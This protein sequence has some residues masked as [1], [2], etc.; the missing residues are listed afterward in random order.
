MPA[1][2]IPVADRTE[3]RRAAVLILRRHRSMA[4]ASLSAY[5]ASVA[6]GL[7]S[8]YLLGLVVDQVRNGTDR[9]WAIAGWMLA[10]LAIEAVT[11]W[12]ATYLSGVLAETI[13]AELREDAIRSVLAAPLATVEAIPVGELLSRVT[14]DIDALVRGTRN[15]LPAV[16]VTS[17]MM[18]MTLG[19]MV[20]LGWE[21]LVAFLL[22]LPILIPVTR[23]FLRRSRP[24]FL[25]NQAAKAVAT[26]VLA[27]SGA[28]AST[29]A[30][31]GWGSWWDRRI[32]NACNDVRDAERGVLRLQS[33]F[34]VIADFGRNIPIAM[35]LLLG[36]IA[37]L[38]DATPLAVVTAGALYAQNLAV[39]I[40]TVLAHQ[41]QLQVGGA[42]FARIL[43]LQGFVHSSASEKVLE[44][45]NS[46]GRTSVDTTADLIVSEVF[47]SYPCDP[48][49][50]SVRDVLEGITLTVPAG[51]RVAIVGPSGAGKTTLGRVISG[52]D[53]PRSGGIRYGDVPLA[54]L[55]SEV[56]RRT[57]GMLS[58][59]SFVFSGSVADN[60]RIAA[61]TANDENLAEVLAAV[62]AASLL[63]TFMLDRPIAEG[64]RPLTPVEEQQLS[65]ARMVLAKPQ[66][67]V[68]DEA[69]AQFDPLT[70]RHLETAVRQ[71]LFGSTIITIAHRLRIA[72][73]ADRV[74]VMAAGAVVQD[75]T[76]DQL[77]A[78]DGPYRTLWSDWEN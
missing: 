34:W 43:G 50:G 11:L 37:Y 26:Q 72:Q 58:Q 39:H 4:L 2:V 1:S 14:R 35:V 55:P 32:I 31:H 25:A 66:V 12:L 46:D 13:A 60:L 3:V 36:G 54:E 68:L 78:R 10:A 15:S 45:H 62:G 71:L 59:H 7:L 73:D 42:A 18:V 17:L 47:F 75:G 74:L 61:P 48:S 70:A 77:I 28:G 51:Q 5:A 27:E 40:D 21:Y 53:A 56:V 69:T 9:V 67:V 6:A 22:C 24:A 30:R 64:P 38:H 29:L 20:L 63:N 41:N 65:L 19:A 8:P 33:T 44:S 76:H 23:W 49:R 52:L 16:I 57:V